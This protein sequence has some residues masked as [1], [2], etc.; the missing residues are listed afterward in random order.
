[1]S[2][3]TK[4]NAEGW[5]AESPRTQKRVMLSMGGKGGVGKTSDGDFGGMV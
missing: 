1:M 4:T 5:H 2:T 3:V